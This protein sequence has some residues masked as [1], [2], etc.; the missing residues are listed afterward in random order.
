MCYYKM[1][2]SSK[3][4]VLMVVKVPKKLIK[5]WKMFNYVDQQKLVKILGDLTELLYVTPRPDLIE[6]LLTF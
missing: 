5:W 2:F 3:S 4:R 6:A 1:D